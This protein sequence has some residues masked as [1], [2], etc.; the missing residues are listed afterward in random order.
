MLQKPPRAKRVDARIEAVTPRDELLQLTPGRDA[1]KHFI[2]E[3]VEAEEAAPQ[4]DLPDISVLTQAAEESDKAAARAEGVQDSAIEELRL[5][6]QEE[7]PLAGAL[8]GAESDIANAVAAVEVIENRL[9]WA[10]LT[11]D[12]ASTHEAAAEASVKLEDAQRDAAAH[13]VASITRKVEVID[14]RTRAAGETRVR[15]ETDIARLEGT[16]QSEGGLGLADRTAGANEEVEA[17]REA[18][19]RVTEEA[20][21][22]R[23]LRR[24][25]EAARNDTSAKF[26]GPV[27]IRAKRYIERLLPG[28]DL[29]FSED[30][31]LESV[32][33]AVPMKIALRCRRARR[34][35]WLYSRALR[36]PTCCLRRERPSRLSSTTRSS[37]RT[38]RVSIR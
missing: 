3:L 36:L 21:T 24:T 26:V 27:A 30:L 20:D 35:S 16:I 11:E 10:S 22:L 6:E 15:L 33:R 31:G 7:A 5:I 28:C 23:L 2:S 4:G 17:A 34:S 9:E 38:M 25:L 14:A 18:L 19:V 8:V 13:D 29:T 12:L 37:I 32:I 1:L